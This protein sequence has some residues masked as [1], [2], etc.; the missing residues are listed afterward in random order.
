MLFTSIEG[1]KVRV[2]K[3]IGS[4]AARDQYL[5]AGNQCCQLDQMF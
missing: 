3:T 1:S 5:I 4:S 2:C